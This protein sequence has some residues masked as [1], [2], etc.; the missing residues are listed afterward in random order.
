M[1]SRRKKRSRFFGQSVFEIN[2][3]C[4]CGSPHEGV[5]LQKLVNPLNIDVGEGPCALP[6]KKAESF[7]W[8]I[9][10]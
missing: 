2:L 1:L 5:P 4:N 6:Q 10:L 9:S 8:A 7:F 3:Y